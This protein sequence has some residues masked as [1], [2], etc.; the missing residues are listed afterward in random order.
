MAQFR[1]PNR[2]IVPKPDFDIDVS[3]KRVL[4]AF[5][6][7]HQSIEMN[8]AAREAFVGYQTLL[9]V[10]A[11]AAANANSDDLS[12]HMSIAPWHLGILAALML[13]F[14]I[15][16]GTEEHHGHGTPVARKPRQHFAREFGGSVFKI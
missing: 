3:S 2:Q 15:F 1:I 6:T 8:C 14:D 10:R 12:T 13:V 16:V 9:K 4:N 11:N 5:Q 7:P